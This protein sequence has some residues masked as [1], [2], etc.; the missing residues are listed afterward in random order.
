MKNVIFL[1][2]ASDDI[3]CYDTMKNTL[4]LYYKPYE[5]SHNFKYF[6]IYLDESLTDDILVKENNIYVKGTESIIPGILKKTMIALNY[7]NCTYDY[8]ILVRT[9]LSSF[10]NLDNLYNL[11]D[12]NIFDVQTEAIGYRPF[13][14]FLSGTSIILS[15][16]IALRLYNEF[17]N[18]KDTI[19][20]DVII[21]TLLQKL[22]IN[23]KSLPNT[24]TNKMLID[25]NQPLPNDSSNILFFRVKS[26]NRTY[27]ADIVFD[28]LAKM[29]TQ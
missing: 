21:S 17:N 2:I 13:N 6:F 3:S 28:H 9:N 8:D 1:I 11:L 26:Q 10:Y 29:L 25:I 12:S 22:G 4:N 16:T 7:I 23:F 18:Y 24:H 15:K 19:P 5:K 20:D 14:T 27:D